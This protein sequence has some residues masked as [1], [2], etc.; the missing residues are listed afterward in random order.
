MI[1][2]VT[3]TLDKEFRR[4]NRAALIFWALILAAQAIVFALLFAVYWQ[5]AQSDWAPHLLIAGVVLLS[6]GVVMFYGLYWLRARL[7][8]A[9]M[10]AV[11]QELHQLH[12]ANDRARSLQAMAA[13]L[14]ATL[15]FERV[16][17]Q[18]LDVCS[19][20]LGEMGIPR[21]SLVGAVFLFEEETLRPLAK[22]RFLGLDEEKTLPGRSGV[23][24][25][26]LRQ[27]APAVTDNPAQDP[28]LSAFAAFQ[29]CLTAVTVPLRA[30]FQLF[31]VMVIGTDTAV[32]FDEDHF[33]LFSAVADQTVIALQNA[34]LYQRLEAEKQR[35][36]AVDDA[37]RKELARDL[38]DGPTQ[39]I[40]AIAMR[41]S[42][43]RKRVVEDPAWVAAELEKIQ[44]LA[45]KT[46]RDIRG[47][48]FTLRPLILETQGL[49]P[50]IET[51]MKRIQEADGGLEMRLIGGEY[52]GLL[53]EKAQ[54]VVFAIIEEAL[55]NARKYAQAGVV[56]VHMWQEDGLFVASITDNGV[57]FEPED[58]ARDYSA[59]GSLGLLNMRE[60]AERIDGSVS[61][62]SA[63]DAGTT[64]TLVVPL[65]KHGREVRTGNE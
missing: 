55:T 26:A 16:V 29:E 43:L 63:P 49:G 4:L 17:E 20:A 39:N 50:A 7:N 64:V 23:V 27:A 19:L 38:H 9:L 28:E 35:L 15:S 46:S 60:R 36:I 65:D 40:A 6:G 62:E 32:Q 5:R 37:A 51:I 2:D 31:G 53:S 12:A 57:G 42:F 52:G 59:R 45:E 61:I 56:E 30:G 24:G 34:Q 8:A 48:L 41:L 22:R 54:G 14:S 13:T 47:M 3:T 44:Q 58:I 10:A 21:E 25:M 1:K 18:A 33:N 11:G